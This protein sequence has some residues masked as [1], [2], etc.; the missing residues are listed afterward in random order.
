MWNSCIWYGEDTILFV[1]KVLHCRFADGRN[2]RARLHPLNM[3]HQMVF[4]LLSDHCA[5]RESQSLNLYMMAQWPKLL[6][7]WAPI[8]DRLGSV[9]TQNY[10]FL[11]FQYF[12][13]LILHVSH[14]CIS[15]STNSLQ[16]TDWTIWTFPLR[17]FLG[18]ALSTMVS[19]STVHR[20]RTQGKDIMPMI[21]DDI[22]PCW[23]VA[24]SPMR[25]SKLVLNYF[26]YF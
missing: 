1:K 23:Y 2:G 3:I 5:S 16:K 11:I 4:I 14:F 9:I 21:K 13:L 19:V 22:V 24:I 8:V 20:V 15:F 12:S 18:P 25:F 17:W 10:N 6:I 26:V 7:W